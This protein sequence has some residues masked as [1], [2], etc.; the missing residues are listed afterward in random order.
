MNPKAL[1]QALAVIRPT[2]RPVMIWGQPGVGKSSIVAQDAKRAGDS[3]L[4]W[5]LPL[6]DPVDLTGTPFTSAHPDDKQPATFWAPPAELPRKGRWTIFMDE[7]PQARTETANAARQLI[8]DRALGSY[9]LPDDVWVVAAGNLDG[10][11]A[12]TNRMPTHIANSFIHLTL[13]VSLPDWVEWAEAN[14]ID[15]RV[16]AFL[17]YRGVEFLHRF[18]PKS[19]E[20]AFA[21]PRSWAFVSQVM[22]SYEI[23][24]GVGEQRWSAAES[25]ELVGGVVGKEVAGE[26]VGFLRIMEGLV[27]VDQILLD[28]ANAPV[29]KDGAISYALC[30]ALAE[31]ASRKTFD[32]IVTY[33]ERLSKEFQFLFMRKVGEKKDDLHKTKTFITW[34]AKNKDFV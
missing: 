11:R 24:G 27:T 29:S 14:S 4:D 8:L 10:D 12:A 25:M 32:L 15:P 6:K 3:L 1:A 19:T 21:S 7:L 20:K 18:D 34:A 2:R 5:R 26:F 9:R 17:K 33:V 28:P 16:V 30:G 13:D 31:R 23:G 22:G